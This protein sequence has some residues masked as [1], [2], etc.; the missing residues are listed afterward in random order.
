MTFY[1]KFSE[2][3]DK[4]MLKMHVHPEARLERINDFVRTLTAEREYHNRCSEL[5]RL[6]IA[7][8]EFESLAFLFTRRHSTYENLW[9]GVERGYRVVHGHMRKLMVE[10]FFKQQQQQPQQI[11]AR[12][13]LFAQWLGLRNQSSSSAAVVIPVSSSSSSSSN[14]IGTCDLALV[15][16]IMSNLQQPDAFLDVMKRLNLVYHMCLLMQADHETT[17]TASGALHRVMLQPF[18]VSPFHDESSTEKSSCCP[19]AESVAYVSLESLH[20]YDDEDDDSTSDELFAVMMRLFRR[21]ASVDG[22]DDCSSG[23]SD[24]EARRR[25][26]NAALSLRFRSLPAVARLSALMRRISDDVIAMIATGARTRGDRGTEE[27]R[28]LIDQVA[29]I[30]SGYFDKSENRCC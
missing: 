25:N 11:K 9:R 28:K 5:D 15:R 26:S 16:S 24:A 22:D 29:V 18:I 1:S 27:I 21:F 4:R 7:V 6:V 30:V 10:Q 17:L 19:L 8:T 2:L 20:T 3:Q 12:R 14:S 13:S 23:N